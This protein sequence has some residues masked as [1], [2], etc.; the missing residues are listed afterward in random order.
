MN[1]P[2]GGA[3]ESGPGD[4]ASFEQ[5]LE[6]LEQIV[7]RLERGDLELEDALGAFEEGVA[8]TKSCAARL[9]EAERRIDVLVREGRQ[10]V[11]RPFEADD[12]EEPE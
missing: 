9:E 3:R 11:A 5:S 12:A 10:W 4:D 7:E 6:R 1:D 2:T 8:L